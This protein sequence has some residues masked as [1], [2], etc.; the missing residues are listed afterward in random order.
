MGDRRSESLTR[1]DLA[2]EMER[3]WMHIDGEAVA[4]VEVGVSTSRRGS[5]WIGWCFGED[6]G[7]DMSARRVVGGRVRA[8]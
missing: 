2:L 5:M 8:W 6:V 3:A 4:E 1:I 7:V